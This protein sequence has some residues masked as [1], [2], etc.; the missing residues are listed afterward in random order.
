VK[1]LHIVAHA[2]RGG[3]EKNCYHFIAGSS[4]YQHDILVLGEKGP[5]TTEWEHQGIFV[6]HLSILQI[7][8]FAFYKDLKKRLE[9]LQFDLVICWSTI[10]LPLQLSALKNATTEVRVHLG[11]PL[12]HQ[13]FK[14]M[15]LNW[16]FPNSGHIKLMACSNYVAK[17]YA[18]APYFKQF[19]IQTSLNPIALP[20]AMPQK[21]KGTNTYAIGMVARL[22]PI[23]DHATVLKAF[24]LVLQQIPNISLHLVGDGVLRKTLEQQVEGLKMSDK[25]VFHGD[26]SN[27]YDYLNEWD[28]FVY[29]TTPNEGLGSVVAEAMANGLPCV[30]SD[31]PMLRELAPQKELALFFE[32]GNAVALVEQLLHLLPNE[33][34]RTSMGIAAYHHAQQHFGAERFVKD[35]L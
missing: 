3:C 33:L 20:A 13:L 29:A 12:H 9:N 32:A 5:M 4:N 17:T 6:Q 16:L 1:V 25:V 34:V 35:Y 27:V 7:G 15:V 28:V 18:S 21:R 31:L 22:D 14:D 23:K 19:D 26:V 24:H 10:R 2:H 30:L 11:N 8:M